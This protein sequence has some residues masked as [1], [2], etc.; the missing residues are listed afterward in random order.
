M[1]V[2][3]LYTY[4]LI[5]FYI[6]IKKILKI[7]QVINIYFFVLIISTISITFGEY[8]YIYNSEIYFSII[9]NIRYN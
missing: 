7:Y 4:M 6:Y 2:Y 8:I 9:F 5:Y 3:I 1:C